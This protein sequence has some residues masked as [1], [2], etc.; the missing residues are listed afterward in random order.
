[1]L[2]SNGLEISGPACKWKI[3]SRVESANGQCSRSAISASQGLMGGYKWSNPYFLLVL[4]N[5]SLVT[6]NDLCCFGCRYGLLFF[7]TE[8][9]II[10]PCGCKRLFLIKI[11]IFDLSSSHW[12]CSEISSVHQRYLNCQYLY[13]FF[14][15]FVVSI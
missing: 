9:V 1:M 12:I 4:W 5:H 10:S 14:Y 2:Q 7:K 3:S 13:I 6:M 11:K 8:I 15:I